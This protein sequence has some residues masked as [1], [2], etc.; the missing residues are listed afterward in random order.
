M[1][2]RNVL[3]VAAV[4]A[5]ASAVYP[6]VAADKSIDSDD[7]VTIQSIEANEDEKT[8]EHHLSNL[9]AEAAKDSS[10]PVADFE[11]PRELSDAFLMS[12][13][14]IVV[15]EIG[16]K[17]F[18]VAA[19][20]A[21]KHPRAVVFSAAFAALVL[22][23]VLSGVVGHALPALIPQR[24]TQFFA[25]VLFIVFGINLLREGLSMSKDAGMGDEMA[26]VEEEIEISA[27]NQRS[28]SLEEAAGPGAVVKK[29]LWK[30]AISHVSNLASYILSPVWV[31]T[32]AMTFLGEWGDRSQI[33]TIAMAAGSDYWMV[34]L[35]G[36]V[37][38]G[39]C[40]GLAVIGGQL[41]A[42]KISMRNVTLGGSIAFFVFSILYFYSAYY[43]LES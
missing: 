1:K 31:Q 15:S 22:M 17:T 35:G 12:T 34:I 43:D 23:T 25:G 4:L 37:G 28:G 13:S 39:L 40:T 5:A 9:K 36:I 11:A 14:M 10:G 42:T 24:L 33:A 29:P 2:V 32:F 7:L 38:H 30:E 26:E 41:L 19:L 18:L 20:M 21:M 3:A 16:D 27:L 6:P 8:L